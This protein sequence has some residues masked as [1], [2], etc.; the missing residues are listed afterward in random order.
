MFRTIYSLL[1]P[2]VHFW[3]CLCLAE[4]FDKYNALRK[5]EEDDSYLRL[6]W[7]GEV[8]HDISIPE[9][10][11]LWR[12]VFRRGVEMR[13]NICGGKFEMWRLFMTDANSL[14]VKKMMCDT[15]D[16]ELR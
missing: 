10:A 15:S 3:K 2:C 12:K 13:R 7:S 4:G 16:N 1:L 5:E 6:T 9:E 11:S 14:P 8:F